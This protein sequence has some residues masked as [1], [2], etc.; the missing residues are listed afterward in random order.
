MPHAHSLHHA[1]AYYLALLHSLH[2]TFTLTLNSVVTY[3]QSNTVPR[4][5]LLNIYSDRST[6]RYTQGSQQSTA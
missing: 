5:G 2:F 6:P 4:F 1:T 3:R